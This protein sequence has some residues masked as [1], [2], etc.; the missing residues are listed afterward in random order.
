MII[1]RYASYF[2]ASL[3]FSAKLRD[4]LAILLP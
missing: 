1:L 4:N 2:Y 3:E